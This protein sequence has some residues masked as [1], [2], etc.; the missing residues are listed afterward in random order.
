M[1]KTFLLYI[2]IL[3]TFNNCDFKS[4]YTFIA[5]NSTNDTI[6]MK[7]V[8]HDIYEY[9]DVNKEEVVLNSQE[10]KIIRVVSSEKQFNSKAHDCLTMHGMDYFSEL[11]FD[12]YVNNVKLEIQ[13]YKAENWIYEKTSDFSATYY[14]TITNEMLENQ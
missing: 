9:S 5:K 2:L 4:S 14:M 7:F 12:T 11:I 3:I 6:V 1:K 8:N 13:L 10:E